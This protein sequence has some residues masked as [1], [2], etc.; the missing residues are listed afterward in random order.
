MAA[1]RFCSLQQMS[2][3]SLRCPWSGC[4]A[5]EDVQP[6]KQIEY[7][8]IERSAAFWGACRNLVP[9]MAKENAE[10]FT[11]T[12]FTHL[13]K[14][15]RWKHPRVFSWK[16]FCIQESIWNSSELEVKHGITLKESS[17]HLCHFRLNLSPLSFWNI[18]LHMSSIMFEL[19]PL[20]S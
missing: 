13:L 12:L 7:I 9:H 3:G 11:E 14:Q 2:V 20:N 18:Y 16:T 5:R 10:I 15:K 6:A 19:N 4:I 1:F 17:S 8:N